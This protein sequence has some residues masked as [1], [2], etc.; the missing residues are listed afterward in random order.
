MS[1]LL[2]WNVCVKAGAGTGNSAVQG[3]WENLLLGESRSVQLN[4]T[5]NN[6]PIFSKTTGAETLDSF[7]V[8]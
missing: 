8:I 6:W 2:F 3:G 5:D 4:T 1:P 7:S